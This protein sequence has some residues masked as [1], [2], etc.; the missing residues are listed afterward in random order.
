M[1]ITLISQWTDGNGNV[2]LVK[3]GCHQCEYC[4]SFI[5]GLFGFLIVF[6]FGNHD[7]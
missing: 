2:D 1:Q 7:E 4:N 6:D 3:I 5:F